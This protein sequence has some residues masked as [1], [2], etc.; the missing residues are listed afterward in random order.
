MKG[1]PQRSIRSLGVTQILM[2]ESICSKPDSAYGTAIAADVS[3]TLSEEVSDAQTFMTLGRLEENGLI[4]EIPQGH[5]DVT[6]PLV[7]VIK[8]RGRPR[9]HYRL[10]PK[11]AAALDQFSAVFDEVVGRLKN[12]RT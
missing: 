8:T 3:K 6:S 4:E 1:I 5:P 2:L 9:K 10:T 12:V 11:G 7:N